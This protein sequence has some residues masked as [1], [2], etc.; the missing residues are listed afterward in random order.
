MR[1]G[2]TTARGG[3]TTAAGSGAVGRGSLGGGAGRGETG[4]RRRPRL[5][6]RAAILVLVLA[7]LTVSYASSARAY[8][9]QRADLEQ[10]QGDIARKQQE[11]KRLQAEKDR[12][13]DPAFLAQT[14]RERFGY[15][16]AGDTCYVVL[17]RDGTPLRAESRL[18]DPTDVGGPTT[19]RAWWDDAWRSAQV[20]GDPP[21]DSQAPPAT[22]ID[23]S[24]EPRG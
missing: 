24:K 15:C 19:P 17:D 11:I 1:G 13:Q 14:A 21:Q 9:R 12:Y 16:A 18:G 10:V 5:T 8:L 6:G 4:G 20:A 7:V 22:L 2:S 23:G 3:S